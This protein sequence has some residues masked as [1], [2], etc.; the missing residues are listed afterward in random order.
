MGYP[1]MAKKITSINGWES[2]S[3]KDLAQLTGLSPVLIGA[4]LRYHKKHNGI[5]QDTKPYKKTH[6]TLIREMMDISGWET[7]NPLDLAKMLGCKPITAKV[8]VWKKQNNPWLGMGTGR[9]IGEPHW[10]KREKVEQIP[11]PFKFVKKD[12]YISI[13]VG[14]A[15]GNVPS[16]SKKDIKNPVKKIK[17]KKVYEPCGCGKCALGKQT[18]ACYHKELAKTKRDVPSLDYINSKSFC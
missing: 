10:S 2:K 15:L 18:D 16:W 14:R 8:I 12:E 3:G 13:Q 11:S 9:K 5:I 7:I 1:D 17:E 6:N 4:V